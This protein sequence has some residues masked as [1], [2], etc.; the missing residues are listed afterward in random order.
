MTPAANLKEPSTRLVSID[1]LRGFDMLLIAGGGAFIEALKGQTGFTWIDALANQLTHPKWFGFSFYDFIFPL[2]L[3]IAGISIPF[4]I[5]KSIT[6]GSNK[7]EILKKAFRRMVILIILGIIDKNTPIT[8]FEPQNIRV[9][10]VLGRIG[11]AGFFATLLYINTSTALKRIYWIAGIL[12][13]YYLIV[14][15]PGLGAGDL[16]KEGNIAGRF[17]R[18]FLPGRL[19][20]K[21]Y[22]ENGLLTQLPAMCL[23]MLGTLAGDILRSAKSAG[24]KLK[25]L[26]LSGIICI[27]LALLWSMHFPI[28]K[29]MWTSSFILLTAGMSFLVFALFYLV[30][31]IWQFKKW[32]FFFYVIGLNSLT[33]YLLYRFVNFEEIARLLFSGLYAP[34]DPKFHPALQALGGLLIVWSILYFLYRKKIFIKI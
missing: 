17:D 21:I 11:I 31:D 2:F 32:A 26:V 5:Y 4:S 28:F 3:F 12:L 20:E 8:F 10:S 7:Q 24:W 15:L 30:I 16:S 18:S 29:K 33:I 14:F 6:S 13:L 25:T 23:T 34:V 9:A 27:I 22:D 1:T 19:L